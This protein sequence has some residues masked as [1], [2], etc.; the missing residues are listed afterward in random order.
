MSDFLTGVTSHKERRIR[1]DYQ[2]RV[3]NSTADFVE[4]YRQSH[5][6]QRMQA[7]LDEHLANTGALEQESS[8]TLAVVQREKHK[9]AVKSQP[10]TVGLGRQVQVAFTREIQLRLADKFSFW[11]RQ[12]TIAL[13]SFGESVCF[14]DP[15]RGSP[16]APAVI[17]SAF[18]NIPDDTNGL[19]LRGGAA[20]LAFIFPTLLAL[21]ETTA[22]FEGRAVLSKHNSFK[23]FRPTVSG[24]S[25]A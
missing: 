3:P 14:S 8:D 7:E 19:F 2:G 23:L 12:G 5:V 24:V 4:C 13:Q 17:A 22:A 18:Y 9:S 1:K 6:R 10:Y 25:A 11:A 20:L 16:P 15:A 21:S